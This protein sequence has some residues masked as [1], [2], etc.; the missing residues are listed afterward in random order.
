MAALLA[1]HPGAAKEKAVRPHLLHTIFRDDA[2]I[3]WLT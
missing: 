3:R 2:C 1:A